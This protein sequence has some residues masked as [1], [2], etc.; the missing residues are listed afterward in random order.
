MLEKVDL[1]AV[2]AFLIRGQLYWIFEIARFIEI[3]QVYAQLREEKIMWIS[4]YPYQKGAQLWEEKIM[5]I[6]P[7]PCKRGYNLS[8]MWLDS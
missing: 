3:G 2:S 5:W 8:K 7:S 4:P 1:I 6:S